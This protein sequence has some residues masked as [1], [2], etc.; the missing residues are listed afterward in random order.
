MSLGATNMTDEQRVVTE[1]VIRRLLA[2][3]G[4]AKSICP[5]EVA[6]RIDPAAWRNRMNDVREV[7]FALAACGQIEITQGGRRIEGLRN[8]RGPIRLRLPQR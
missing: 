1:A 2:E 6:R 3:R 7:A 5:S 4:P 8:A